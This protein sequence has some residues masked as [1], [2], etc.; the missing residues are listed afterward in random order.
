MKRIATL[1]ALLYAMVAVAGKPENAEREPAKFSIG[2]H[3]GV[4]I[5]AAV[6]WPPGKVMGGE[7]KMRATPK[8]TP[9]LGLSFTK[10]LDERWSLTLETTYKV[11]ELDAKAWVEEQTFV[12][13]GYDPWIWVSFRGTA[14]MDMS[15]PMLE[16]PLYTRYTF[17]NGNHSVFLGGYYARVFNAKFVTTPYK[18]MLFNVSDGKPDYDHPKGTVLPDS[19]Y[20]QNFNDAMSRWDAGFI[21]GYEMKIFP[22]IML[23]GRYSMGFND[24]FQPDK[25]YLTYNMLHMRGTLALSYMLINK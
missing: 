7:N 22:R 4:D 15:F 17:K 1:A 12:D 8:L 5:G 3:T 23:S 24:I 16:I 19:P 21:A 11:V 9:A 20:T 14:F 25:K 6:P 2:I 18:G 13:R 10:V